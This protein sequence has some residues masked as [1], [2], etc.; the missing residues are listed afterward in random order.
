MKGKVMRRKL[1]T[2]RRISSPFD[3][4]ASLK[5]LRRRRVR[6]TVRTPIPDED[7]MMTS[8]PQSNKLTTTRIPSNRLNPSFAYPLRLKAYILNS[9]S[10]VKITVNILLKKSSLS[11]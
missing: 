8:I 4:V 11:S 9:I 1:F 6:K 2:V 3:L 10:T 5:T 7:P